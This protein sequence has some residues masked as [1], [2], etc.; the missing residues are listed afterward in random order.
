[1]Q[2]MLYM[3]RMLT[4]NKVKVISKIKI[5]KMKILNSYYTDESK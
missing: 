3:H 5:S 2:H 1:M 4:E